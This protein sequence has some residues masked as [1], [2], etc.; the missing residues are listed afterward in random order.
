MCLDFCAKALQACQNAFTSNV[1]LIC[2]LLIYHYAQWQ[3]TPPY[4][5]NT[6][7]RH[8]TATED[9]KKWRLKYPYESFLRSKLTQYFLHLFIAI[10]IIIMIIITL[11]IIIAIIII[12]DLTIINIIRIFFLGG[13][14]RS[15]GFSLRWGRG[16]RESP[17]L[18]S[19]PDLTLSL[20]MW[21]LVKFDSTPFFIGYYKKVAAMQSTLRLALFRGT[22]SEGLVF[23]SSC[24][25]LNKC[26]LCGGKFCFFP[27]P[28]KLY[29]WGKSFKKFASFVLMVPTKAPSTL[30]LE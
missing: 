5:V 7:K 24:A 4:T 18:I 13:Q 3:S 12:I 22:L 2:L 17:A 8:V 26:Q 21:D 19:Y 16:G 23:A 25:V 10:I 14:L 6:S 15:Q 9:K 30:P 20:E 11:I 27:T 28:E 29:S 1:N